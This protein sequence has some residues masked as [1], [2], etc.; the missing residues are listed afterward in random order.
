[1]SSTPAPRGTRRAATTA[2]GD[3]SFPAVQHKL[4]A[5]AHALDDI[6]PELEDLIR[7]MRAR[8]D[9]ASSLADRIGQAGLDPKFVEL[10]NLVA[11]ALGGAAREMRTLDESGQEATGQ[12]RDAKKT[13][14]RLYQELD[15]VRSGRREKTPKPGFFTD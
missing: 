4:D 7:G 5:F 9:R 3:H 14:A 15:E 2:D 8:A 11:T 13:H 6:Q 1:M 10:T 12:A